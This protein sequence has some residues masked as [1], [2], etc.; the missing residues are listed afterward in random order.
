MN[1]E[2]YVTPALLGEVARHWRETAEPWLSAD[3]QLA[4]Y[5]PLLDVLGVGR[6]GRSLLRDLHLYGRGVPVEGAHCT[7]DILT[8]IWQ[9][10]E[11]AFW[12]RLKQ[13]VDWGMCEMVGPQSFGRPARGDLPRVPWVRECRLDEEAKAT[14]GAWFVALAV[15]TVEEARQSFE[16]VCHS[17]PLRRWLGAA[18]SEGWWRPWPWRAVGNPSLHVWRHCEPLPRNQPQTLR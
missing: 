11:L 10:P 7:G 18:V 17:E 13:S 3:D 12:N 14:L 1:E 8:R 2:T 4:R 15:G 16:A 5:R 6:E 9:C